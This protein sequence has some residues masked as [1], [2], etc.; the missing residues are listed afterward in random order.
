MICVFGCL[1]NK[2]GMSIYKEMMTW[3]NKE[4]EIIEIHQE[5]P[6]KEFEYPAIKCAIE[7]SIKSNKPI[8]Y[9]HTKGAGNPIP[10]YYKERMMSDDVN[11]P[12]EAKPEDCQR[13]VRMM[14][15]HEFTGERLK[16]YLNTVNK[17]EPIVAC[18]L[19]GKEKLTWQNG[20]IINSLAAKELLKSFHKDEN[21]YYYEC[22]FQNT[23]IK[24]K[25][26]ISEDC[27][28]SDI[29]HAKMW[30]LIWKFYDTAY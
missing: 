12:S 30:N 5:P 4:H 1:D 8:L 19:T 11:Y 3:L 25:G 22:M 16:V 29:H 14:W 2:E 27:N 17:N 9:L 23:N 13:I 21:R 15:K 26:L 20:W 6:G 18:P 24:V 28:L 10:S 7:T